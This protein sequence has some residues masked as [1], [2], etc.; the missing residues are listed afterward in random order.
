MDKV[1]KDMIAMI[2]ALKQDVQDEMPYIKRRVDRIINNKIY[3]QNVIEKELDSLLDLMLIGE[4]VECFK[5]LNEYYE[6]VNEENAKEY[7]KYY[8][9]TIQE[10]E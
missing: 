4:G 10:Y 1:L 3:S 8:K 5:I 9:E 2:E 7:W 6:T